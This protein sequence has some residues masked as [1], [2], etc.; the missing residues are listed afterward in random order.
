LVDLPDFDDATWIPGDHP[1]PPTVGDLYAG[2]PLPAF[3]DAG[4]LVVSGTGDRE[5]LHLAVERRLALVVSTVQELVVVPVTTAD[6]AEDYTRFREVVEMGRTAVP[7]CRLPRLA[8][9]WE[10][11]AL[12]VLYQPISLPYRF[13]EDAPVVRLM[14]MSP[15]AQN[16]LKLRFA[17]LAGSR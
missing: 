5:V 14:A 12:A 4:G 15:E 1:L 3:E 2:V 9:F 7:F 10:E 16:T 6:D 11:D 17:A 8:A 13:F